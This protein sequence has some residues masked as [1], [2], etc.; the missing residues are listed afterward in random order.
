MSAFKSSKPNNRGV[1]EP[2][3]SYT[4]FAEPAWYNAL[5]SPYYS[6]SHRALRKYVR[7][8]IDANIE[9]HADLWEEEGIV[10]ADASLSWIRAGLIFQ[11]LP[12]QYRNGIPLPCNI[13]YEGTWSWPFL[14]KGSSD[15][16]FL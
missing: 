8:Y 16:T 3:G 9:P 12:P 4:P 1:A 5:A 14:R 11:D 2:F 6:D 7:E 13:P 15:L 10:P